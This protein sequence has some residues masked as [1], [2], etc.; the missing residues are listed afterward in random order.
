MEKLKLS[1]IILE[2]KFWRDT[3]DFLNL[4]WSRTKKPFPRGQTT[5]NMNRFGDCLAKDNHLN[6]GDREALYTFCK[7][8][9]GTVDAMKKF[10]ELYKK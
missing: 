7:S 3:N 4:Y 5:Y 10:P 1:Q 8:Y 2:L 9:V 6:K